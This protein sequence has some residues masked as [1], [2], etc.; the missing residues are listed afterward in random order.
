MRNSQQRLIGNGL[1]IYERDAEI[2]KEQ[3][4]RRSL[5]FAKIWAES[6]P[7]YDLPAIDT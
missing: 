3:G 1:R 7:V 2:G 6:D 5:I 4:L